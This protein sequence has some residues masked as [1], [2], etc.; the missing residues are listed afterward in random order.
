M[1]IHESYA[2]RLLHDVPRKFAGLIV[3][4]R[5]RND[6]IACELLGQLLDL[7]L[8]IRQLHTESIC[9]TDH[10]R[11]GQSPTASNGKCLETET[12]APHDAITKYDELAEPVAKGMYLCC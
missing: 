5:L 10:R 4:L 6:L 7:L 3:I 11:C 12:D 1:R 8:L 9:G 2:V